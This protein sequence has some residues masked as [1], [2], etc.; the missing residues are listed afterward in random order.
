LCNEGGTE[1]GSKQNQTH[2]APMFLE[3]ARIEGF[4]QSKNFSYLEPHNKFNPKKEKGKTRNPGFLSKA[5]KLD[6]TNVN[7]SLA[8][9]V[10]HLY[11]LFDLLLYCTHL[12][13]KLV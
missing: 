7:Q 6:N 10:Q 2:R 4:K 9:S 13:C 1:I 3:D 5:K 8:L 11:F 12:W